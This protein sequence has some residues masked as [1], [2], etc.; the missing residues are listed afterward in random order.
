MKLNNQKYIRYTL[1]ILQNNYSGIRIAEELDMLDNLNE[2]L[3][4]ED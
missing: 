4:E 2:E 1:T 3:P